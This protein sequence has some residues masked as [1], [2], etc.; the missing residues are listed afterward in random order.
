[1]TL[2]LQPTREIISGV[3]AE[4]EAAKHG[5]VSR[6]DIGRAAQQLVKLRTDRLADGQVL[7]AY[8]IP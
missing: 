6:F 4:L 3:G 1:M 5:A 7:G 2:P 8:E